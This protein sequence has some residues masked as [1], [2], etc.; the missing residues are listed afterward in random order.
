MEIL[1]AGLNHKSASIDIR[2]GLAFDSLHVTA[3]LKMLK[4]RFE[5][6]EFALLSTCNRVELYCVSMADS[7][8]FAEDIF[9]FFSEFHNIG[10]EKFRD[11]LYVYKGEKAVS[12]LLSVASSLDSMVV[13]EAQIIGQVKEC[14]RLA[15]GAKSTGKVLNRLFHC[16]FATGKKVH[17]ATSIAMGRVS[18]AGVAVEL[19][20]QLFADISTAQVV[21]LG[22]GQTGELLVQHLSQAGCGTICVINRSYGRAVNMA[23]KYGVTAKKWEE[24]NEQL[25]DADIVIASASVQDYLFRKSAFGD[26][27]KKRDKGALLIIDIAVPRNF[28]ACVN[29]IEDVYLYSIDDLSEVVEQNLKARNEDVANG[30]RIVFENTAEFMDWFKARD[31]GPLIGQMKEKFG[32]ISRKELERFFADSKLEASSREEMETMVSRVVKRLLHSVIKDVNKVSKEQGAT[33]AA[34]LVQSIVSEAQAALEP[35]RKEEEQQ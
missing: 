24:L 18:I 16:A 1:V 30:M 6:A 35:A 26:I 3:A 23:E 19:A 13:G 32:E 15:C 33:E 25:V 11:Y 8:P 9:Q 21:V 10:L 20:L 4:D 31:I 14:Y 34:K 29:E 28:E 2:E 27:I 5:E 12:H 22:A 17:T 7:K